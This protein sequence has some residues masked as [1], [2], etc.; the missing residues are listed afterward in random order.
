MGDNVPGGKRANGVVGFD[1][2]RGTNVRIL[3]QGSQS[4]RWLPSIGANAAVR[5]RPSTCGARTRAS[6]ERPCPHGPDLSRFV[7][8]GERMGAGTS[9]ERGR[10]WRG[11]AQIVRKLT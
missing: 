6:Q 11:L 2:L 4:P 10:S 1:W 3:G 9:L 7:E 5:V 8:I